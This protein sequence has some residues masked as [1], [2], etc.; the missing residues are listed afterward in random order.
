MPFDY[1]WLA[2]STAIVYF[3]RGGDFVLL[4]LNRLGAGCWQDES[5][6]NIVY[7]DWSPYYRTLIVIFEENSSI[8]RCL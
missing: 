8:P 1:L 4:L 5:I 2:L 6:L 7:N 3:N